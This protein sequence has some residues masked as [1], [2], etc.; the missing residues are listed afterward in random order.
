M[1]KKVLVKIHLLIKV[2]T[3]KTPNNLLVSVFPLLIQ[4]ILFCF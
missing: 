4:S 1:A 2:N 3:E